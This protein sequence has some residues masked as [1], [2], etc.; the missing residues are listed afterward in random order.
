[1]MRVLL[2]SFVLVSFF[3]LAGV[4][5]SAQTPATAP[6]ATPLIAPGKAA[7]KPT[8]PNAD[9]VPLPVVSDVAGS[10]SVEA[11]LLPSSVAKR[12]FGKA[13]SDQY[14]VVQMTISNHN[15]NAALIIQS[16][17]LDYS[18]WLFSN[19][20]QAPVSRPRSIETTPFQAANNPSQVAS[21]EARLVRGNLQDAQFWTARNTFIRAI[22]A[23]GTVASAF[24]F[25]APSQDYNAG[26]SAFGNQVVPALATFWPDQTQPQINRIS[27]F[28]FQT[29][30]VIPKGS[31][32]I[33]VA[34]FPIDRF[35]T[36]SLRK[37][38]VKSSPAIFYV[39]GEMLIDTKY[40]STLVSMLRNAGVI[41]EKDDQV[42][43]G[44]ISTAL[45]R[46]EALQVCEASRSEKCGNLKDDEL[47]KCKNKFTSETCAKV[48]ENERSACEASK[49]CLGLDDSQKLILSILNKVS[50]NNIRVVIGG[51]M[52]VDTNAVPAIIDSVA[53][54]EDASN[55]D[56]WKSGSTVHAVITGSFLSGGVPS[57]VGSANLGIGDP[58]VDSQNSTDKKLSFS[59]TLSKDIPGGTK[60]QFVV[61]KRAND[62]SSTESKP[63]ELAVT[64]NAPALS[65]TITDPSKAATWK[66]GS[67]VHGAIA[68][69]SL[70][71]AALKVVNSE[72]L[73]IGDPVVDTKNS[74]DTK[75]A[76][77]FALT[78]DVSTDTKLQF[79][80]TKPS[81][82]GSA[83]VVERVDFT[84]KYGPGDAS[85]V[86]VQPTKGTND[87]N[88]APGSASPAK[89][90]VN[91]NSPKKSERNSAPRTNLN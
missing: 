56:T 80:V 32:D 78:K 52:T 72:D 54:S 69:S 61:T 31:S 35:L 39:P 89:P 87:Q 8:I 10:V 30:H 74:T 15:P 57:I 67:T 47:T 14:A 79:I 62:G 59:F 1:M 45:G 64:Y 17:F 3:P 34:F 76:F 4:L 51:I 71:G 66:S 40:R 42:A 85:T 38:F 29:N 27:D 36:P 12:I 16:A 28:G 68:R 41:T 2:R 53:V 60:L 86:P 20:F 75:L 9:G 50:L 82:D 55:A 18:H 48:K 37:L 91:K 88:A 83:A 90:P 22:T 5:A 25:L 7:A 84:V 73:G 49:G 63:S 6:A 33:V 43:A 46:Y 11:V 44:Q 23:V 13:V 58:V 77:T 81:K 21:T 65:V 19:N 70:S 26:I 24:Q